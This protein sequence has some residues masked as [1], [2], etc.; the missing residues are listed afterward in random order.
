MLEKKTKIV[1]VGNGVLK[2]NLKDKRAV[3]YKNQPQ[4]VDTEDAENLLKLRGK[5]C[6]CHNSEGTL[7][8]ITYDQSKELNN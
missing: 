5:G 3:F 6:R 4:E 8:F 1:F 2:Y 7:L